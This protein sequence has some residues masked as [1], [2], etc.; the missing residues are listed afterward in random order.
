M[1]S[2]PVVQDHII[3][4]KNVPFHQTP[5]LPSPKKTKAPADHVCRGFPRTGLAGCKRSGGPLL[6]TDRSSAETEPTSAGVKVLFRAFSPIL[7]HHEQFLIIPYFSGHCGIFSKGITIDS[8]LLICANIFIFSTNFSTKCT[9]VPR[10]LRLS[11]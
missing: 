2:K 5:F 8:K 10:F 1:T 4:F 11:N 9:P 3:R 7:P 6:C